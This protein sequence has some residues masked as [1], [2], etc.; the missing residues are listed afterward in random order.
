MNE[1]LTIDQQKQRRNKIIASWVI[2][3]ILV[4]ASVWGVVELAKSSAKQ[5]A[6]GQVPAPTSSDHIAGDPNSKTVLIEYAD[7]Q[8]PFCAA[9][10][11]LVTQLL[12]DYPTKFEFVYRNFPLKTIHINAILA[13]TA[14]EAA[15]KQ[16][17]FW[18][19]HD[20]LYQ[21]QNAWA[22]NSNAATIF[23]GYAQQ[24]GL[25][26][27][28]FKQDL[29]DTSKAE[30]DYNTAIKLGLN[31]TPTFFLNGKEVTPTPTDY[32]GFKKLIGVQ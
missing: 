26:V 6:A 21:N 12:K 25:N 31:H 4:A 19:M 23:E 3:V 30:S 8:C 11:P 20:M 28:Q 22:E 1:Y 14:A 2:G 29:A 7:Y 10:Q 13:V 16:R 9:A 32:Q 24:L 27:D 17:K 18:E 15:G 5:V